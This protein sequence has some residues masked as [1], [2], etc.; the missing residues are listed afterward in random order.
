M[1]LR[2]RTRCSLRITSS[3]QTPKSRMRFRQSNAPLCRQTIHPRNSRQRPS[4]SSLSREEWYSE[5]GQRWAHDLPV[6]DLVQRPGKL[7]LFK[8]RI[9]QTSACR[10]PGPTWRHRAA[11][12]IHDVLEGQARRYERG[13]VSEKDVSDDFDSVPH[14]ARRRITVESVHDAAFWS[15]LNAH[16]DQPLAICMGVI[17]ST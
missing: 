11:D 1:S 2:S 5:V 8:T 9:L 4:L 15:F 3:G 17:V 12:A 13:C 16:V 14:E 7:S 10:Y 6:L